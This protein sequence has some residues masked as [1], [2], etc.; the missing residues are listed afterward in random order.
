MPSVLPV[1]IFATARPIPPIDETGHALSGLGLRD[2]ISSIGCLVQQ[3]QSERQTVSFLDFPVAAR[4]PRLAK[5]ASG[6]TPVQMAPTEPFWRTK[7]RSWG[8]NDGNQ[9]SGERSPAHHNP[10][11]HPKVQL[12]TPTSPSPANCMC[13]R[14]N[15]PL[16]LCAQQEP[17]F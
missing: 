12:L 5:R 1:S 9:G 11:Q 6:P 4:S 2:K 3:H 8:S 13:K 14:Q 10:T 17:P 16:S 7:D 15:R